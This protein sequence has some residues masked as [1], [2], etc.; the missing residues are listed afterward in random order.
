MRSVLVEL[1]RKL[2][3][4]IPEKVFLIPLTYLNEGT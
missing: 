1:A 3:S 2:P 4:L